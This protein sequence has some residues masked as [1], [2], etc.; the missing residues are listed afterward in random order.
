M[1]QEQ[2]RRPSRS[3]KRP[4]AARRWPRSW[5]GA[6][7][8]PEHVATAQGFASVSSGCRR[9]EGWGDGRDGTFWSSSASSSSSPVTSMWSRYDASP[10]SL[11]LPG[12]ARR[13]ATGG[14]S[15]VDWRIIFRSC[16]T[17][18]SGGTEGSAAGFGFEGFVAAANICLM[19]S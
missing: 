6:L 12:D 14:M 5:R 1:P 2:P 15:C 19:R 10:A 8:P 4:A 7:S 13:G 9:G 18:I 17:G 11:L 3:S 16:D